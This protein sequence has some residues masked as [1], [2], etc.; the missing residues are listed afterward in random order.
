MATAPFSCL[1]VRAKSLKGNPRVAEAA[2]YFATVVAGLVVDWSLWLILD[3]W[4]D[5]SFGSQAV[6]RVAGGA[7]VYAICKNYTFK[8]SDQSNHV[9]RNYMIAWI[10]SWAMS[11]V[12]IGTLSCFFRPK[13]A[14]I[15]SDGITFTVNYLVMKLWVFKVASTTP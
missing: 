4:T 8:N 14:K 11:I 1:S 6:S 15:I 10:G 5:S 7:V 13:T 12:L 2:R 3:A 9:R